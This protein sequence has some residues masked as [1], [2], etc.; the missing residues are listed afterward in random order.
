MRVDKGKV[1]INTRDFNRKVVLI[2]N[3]NNDEELQ[4]GQFSAMEAVPGCL[5][6]AEEK[7]EKYN[8]FRH[9]NKAERLTMDQVMVVDIRAAEQEENFTN[10]GKQNGSNNEDTL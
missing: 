8:Q 4:A 7:L 3:A 2:R 10:F 5:A 9:D 6:I 1:I